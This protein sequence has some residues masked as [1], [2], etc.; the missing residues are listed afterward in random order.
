MRIDSV[1]ELMRLAIW[2]VGRIW[3]ERLQRLETEDFKGL[4][5]GNSFNVNYPGLHL[6]YTV[7]AVPKGGI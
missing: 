7:R 1:V 5:S 6:Q 2:M 3:Y 4:C